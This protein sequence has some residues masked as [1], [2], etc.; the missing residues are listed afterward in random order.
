MDNLTIL[1]QIESLRELTKLRPLRIRAWAS[2]LE[3]AKSAATEEAQFT[4]MANYHEEIEE[5]EKLGG[6]SSD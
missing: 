4:M 2:A 3:T 6:K 1:N 5:R